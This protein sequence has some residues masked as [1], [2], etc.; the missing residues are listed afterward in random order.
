MA[1][2]L[3]KLIGRMLK[4]GPEY[5]HKGMEFYEKKYRDQYFAISQ[6]KGRQ[7]GF[8]TYSCRGSCRLS[9]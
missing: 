3:A 8:P 6:K 5:V 2:P 4:F 7:A 9:F 1:N